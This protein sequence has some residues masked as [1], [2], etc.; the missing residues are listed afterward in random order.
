MGRGGFINKTKMSLTWGG[1]VLSTKQHFHLLGEGRF[2]KQNNIFTYL[3]RG[4]F[5]NKTK[6][7][8]TWGGEVL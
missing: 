3:G 1:E 8:L 4:G 5:I 2:Y 7:S 6:M